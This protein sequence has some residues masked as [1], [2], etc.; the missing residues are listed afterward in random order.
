MFDINLINKPGI[1]KEGVFSVIS[2]RDAPE[3]R[4][5]DPSAEISRVLKSG[6]KR[7]KLPVFVTFIFIAGLILGGWFYFTDLRPIPVSAD[8]GLKGINDIRF[9]TLLNSGAQI[10][11]D[12]IR[13]KQAKFSKE[14]IIILFAS[15]SQEKLNDFNRQLESVFHLSGKFTGSGNE[16]GELL[17][18]WKYRNGLQSLNGN[19]SM[20]EELNDFFSRKGYA[21]QES[22]RI[23]RGELPEEELSSLL[24]FLDSMNSDFPGMMDLEMNVYPDNRVT[25]SFTYIQSQSGE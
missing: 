19:R 9:F 16:G 2:F 25:Y 18:E 22:G 8:S 4:E 10:L 20:T 13:L 11:P 1:Q 5:P 12:N 24:E 7:S 6:K 17:Y 23:L 15:P 3:D 14:K 21:I